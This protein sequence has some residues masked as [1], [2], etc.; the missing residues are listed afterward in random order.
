MRLIPR[1]HELKFSRD[2]FEG[3]WSKQVLILFVSETKLSL[4]SV[5]LFPHQYNLLL[6]AKLPI[7]DCSIIMNISVINIL[8]KSGPNIEPS[9][10]PRL[11]FY[12]LLITPTSFPP[13]NS[14]IVRISHQNL[15]NFSF[16]FFVTL[17][18]NLEVLSSVSPKSLNLNQ[19][20]PSKKVVFLVK[21]L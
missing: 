19:N 21:P 5:N 12:H 14:T 17:V 10:M 18:W 1:N 13:V 15:L 11:I 3:I 6:S 4:I 9:G 2:G 7:S 16:N 20:Y 8:N